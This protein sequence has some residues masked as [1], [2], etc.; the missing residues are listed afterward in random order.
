MSESLDLHLLKINSHYNLE[1]V[2]ANS[3]VVLEYLS[4]TV[5]PLIKSQNESKLGLIIVREIEQIK[6]KTVVLIFMLIVL[7]V[8][9]YL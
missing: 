9:F 8:I 1:I 5:S 7:K 4:P 6:K 3:L 2:R